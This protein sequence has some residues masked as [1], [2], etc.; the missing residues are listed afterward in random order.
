[1]QNYSIGLFLTFWDTSNLA[2]Y[3]Y[4]HISLLILDINPLE[5]VFS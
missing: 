3:I 2:Q 4:N 1:M 5:N